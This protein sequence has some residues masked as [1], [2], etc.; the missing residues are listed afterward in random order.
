MR[1][2]C[3]KTRNDTAFPVRGRR[4]TRLC[5]SC[6]AI[7]IDKMMLPI[8]GSRVYNLHC[9]LDVWFQT[10]SYLLQTN[11][12]I[13]RQTTFALQHTKENV[14][15]FQCLQTIFGI[16]VSYIIGPTLQ[17]LYT[18]CLTVNDQ[19]Y[20]SHTSKRTI[21]LFPIDHNIYFSI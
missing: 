21:F 8:F 3:V 12:K 17:K 6:W 9:K 5:M 15:P 16:F 10:P 13:C 20:Q 7:Y 1:K 2:I 11:N 4:G 19:S 18:K 14:A